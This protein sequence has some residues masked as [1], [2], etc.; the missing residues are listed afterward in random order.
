MNL[1][2][3]ENYSLSLAVWLATDEYKLPANMADY[4]SVT[5]LLKP[6]RQIILAGRPQ[7]TTQQRDIS[8]NIPA[9]RG[10][11][12][13]DSV[14][15]S[16]KNNYKQAMNDLGYPAEAIK[17]I[18]INPQPHELKP[19]SIPIYLEQRT[20]KRIG[21]YIVGGKYDF[22][23][24][25]ILEDFKTTGVY[26][27]MKGS[28][29]EDYRLQGSMYRWLNQDI[30]TADHMIIQYEF[31]DWSKLRA[32]IEKKKGYP[33]TR[34]LSKK[35][36]LLS[37]AETESFIRNKINQVIKYKDVN[38][39]DLPECTPKELWQ[40][41]PVYKYFKNPAKLSRSTKNFDDYH[42]AH[43]R[44]LKDG[45]IGII[46]EVKGSIRRCGYCSSYNIC[47]QKDAYLANGLIVL[48]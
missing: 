36:V 2:N 32:I 14:E 15:K 28:N 5:G 34:L 19:D 13:H 23:T 11:A 27:Y 37:L 12:F 31:T 25:G 4:I 21:G 1:S 20:M 47:S 35:I 16:W 42:V 22:V 41:P 43:A 26:G 38:E 7:K 24:E 46:Q 40:S 8:T 9:R 33:Q 44:L 17:R 6:I 48:P 29:D 45:S 18:I 10:T 3:N 39:V 30:I